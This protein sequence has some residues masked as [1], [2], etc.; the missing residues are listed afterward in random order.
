MTIIV[1]ISA[2]VV[3]SIDDRRTILGDHRDDR[4]R[5]S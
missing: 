5:S 3:M 2:I 1:T 4:A